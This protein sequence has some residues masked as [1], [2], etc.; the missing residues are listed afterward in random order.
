MKIPLFA[1]ILAFLLVLIGAFFVWRLNGPTEGLLVDGAGNPL[2]GIPIQFEDLHPERWEWEPTSETVTDADG[3]FALPELGEHGVYAKVKS[4]AP[5]PWG[6][7]FGSVL[8]VAHGESSPRLVVRAGGDVRLTIQNADAVE[9]MFS[10]IEGGTGSGWVDIQTR[11]VKSGEELLL[12]RY[13]AG[14]WK[15][16]WQWLPFGDDRET[17]LTRVIQVPAGTGYTG[18]LDLD[19]PWPPAGD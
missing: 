16:Q 2:A 18:T 8:H 19:A 14:A 12:G 4:P 5:A 17:I 1:K 10:M 15:L 13:R 3:V 9:I 6:I 7:G 11:T